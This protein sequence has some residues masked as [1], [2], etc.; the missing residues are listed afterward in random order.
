M[1]DYPL[2]CV[3]LLSFITLITIYIVGTQ[4]P[5]KD[6]V[7]RIMD[8]INEFLVLVLNYHLMCFTNFVIDPYARE[9]LGYSMT[10]VT[11]FFIAIN[12]GYAFNGMFSNSCKRVKYWCI[13]TKNQK[14]LDEARK[15]QLLAIKKSELV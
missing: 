11:C 9:Y 6:R 1:N 12:L 13:R 3:L 5:F 15:K 4:E 2:F 14:K 7:K 8:L 10:V